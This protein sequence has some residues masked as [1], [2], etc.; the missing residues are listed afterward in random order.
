[1]SFSLDRWILFD[2]LHN[3]LTHSYNTSLSDKVNRLNAAFQSVDPH[4]EC[5]DPLHADSNRDAEFVTWAWSTEQFIR[6]IRVWL[7]YSVYSESKDID[8]VC[9]QVTH[10]LL[11]CKN[12]VQICYFCDGCKLRND[13]LN[14]RSMSH[15]TIQKLLRLTYSYL[16]EHHRTFLGGFGMVRL[17][18]ACSQDSQARYSVEGLRPTIRFFLYDIDQSSYYDKHGHWM[19]SRLGAIVQYMA[20]GICDPSIYSCLIPIQESSAGLNA[21]TV[22]HP[23]R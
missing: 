15:S 1:M 11:T 4:L 18:E 23:C 21:L 7:N 8:R 19:Q 22:G 20:T 6:T 12:G 10:S 13:I 16:A 5:T 3:A 9:H 2:C 17:T 14:R